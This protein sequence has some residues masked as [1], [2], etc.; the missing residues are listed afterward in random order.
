[1]PP[2][3]DQ[4]LE[5]RRPEALKA[6]DKSEHHAASPF[7]REAVERLPPRGASPSP[8]ATKLIDASAEA[9]DAELLGVYLEESD[10]V[11]AT[12]REQST[13]FASGRQQEAWSPS[14]GG[15]PHA[16]AA[17]A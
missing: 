10:E 3:A 7:L 13:S 12:I 15:D 6:L 4:K 11:L 9:V 5:T 16:R 14:A 8:E 1:M 17:G 2:V